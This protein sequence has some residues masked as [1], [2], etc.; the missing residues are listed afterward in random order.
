MARITQRSQ[1]RPS[2]DDRRPSIRSESDWRVRI[3]PGTLF[4]MRVR[5]SAFH[6]CRRRRLPELVSLPSARMRLYEIS[7]KI[8]DLTEGARE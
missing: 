3:G 8:R 1:E 2:R 5:R 7:E 4:G 6:P